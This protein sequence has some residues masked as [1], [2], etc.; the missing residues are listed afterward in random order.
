MPSFKIQT[1]R[2]DTPLGF[3]DGNSHGVNVTYSD[4]PTAISSR[5]A[6]RLAPPHVM[7]RYSSVGSEAKQEAKKCHKHK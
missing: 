5:A 6:G 1:I 4:K 7:P 3:A 2:F